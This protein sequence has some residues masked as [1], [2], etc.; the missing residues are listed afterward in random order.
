MFEKSCKWKRN[1]QVKGFCQ[2]AFSSK[3]Q[4]QSN[5]YTSKV[6]D[7]NYLQNQ[8]LKLAH[9]TRRGE[10]QKIIIKRKVTENLE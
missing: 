2:E 7:R 1:F 6:M 5:F 4:K 8:V 10:S 3:S 9:Y